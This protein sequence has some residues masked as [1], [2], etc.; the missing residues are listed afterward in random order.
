MMDDDDFPKPTAV[1]IPAADFQAPPPNR[2]LA[3]KQA[4]PVRQS[5]E[6]R[7]D[8][9]VAVRASVLRRCRGKLASLKTRANVSTE[10]LLAAGTSSLGASLSAL[11][12]GVTLRDP[13]GTFF[14]VALPA[15]GFGS[16]VA[17]ALCRDHSTRSANDAATDILSELPEPDTT[18]P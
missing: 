10:L 14:F 16:L 7:D 8:F 12:S 17:Y 2:D 6:D 9:I 13:S 18:Q 5:R 4:F 15:V 3:I 1:S 11:A